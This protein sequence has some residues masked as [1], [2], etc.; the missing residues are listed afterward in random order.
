MEQDTKL[1]LEKEVLLE[2]IPA[3]HE[4]YGDNVRERDECIAR[5]ENELIRITRYPAR[6]GKPCLYE[7]LRSQGLRSV[8]LFSSRALQLSGEKPDLRILYRYDEEQQLVRIRSIGF[9]QKERPRPGTD[10]Y[11][12][13]GRRTES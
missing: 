10:P 8:K 7:P 2:D 1:K 13:A 11:S 5:I 4:A 12:K 9:R 6:E 3:I